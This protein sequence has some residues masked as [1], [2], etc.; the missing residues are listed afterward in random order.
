MGPADVCAHAGVRWHALVGGCGVARLAR[1]GWRQSCNRQ[2][3]QILHPPS[4]ALLTP[5]ALRLR[6]LRPLRLRPL[7]SILARVVLP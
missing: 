1:L 5:P 4:L 3:T 2:K 7:S 6:L